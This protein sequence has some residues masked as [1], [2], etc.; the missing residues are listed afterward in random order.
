M[1]SLNE[2][3]ERQSGSTPVI[4]GL[5]IIHSKGFHQQIEMAAAISKEF[6]RIVWKHRQI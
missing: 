3:T 6:M 4:T 2:V 5:I 1:Y